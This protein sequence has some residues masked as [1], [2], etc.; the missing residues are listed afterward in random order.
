MTGKE[1]KER[2]GGRVEWLGEIEGQDEIHGLES[3]NGLG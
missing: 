1:R 3:Q 2:G